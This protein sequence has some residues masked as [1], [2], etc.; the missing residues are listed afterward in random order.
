M[1]R[2]ALNILKEWYES[3][4][5]RP[6]YISGF[7]GVG[8]TWLAADFASSFF[9]ES[10]FINF[11]TDG[12]MR[13]I[14]ENAEK[15]VNLEM[16]L[17]ETFSID[18]GILPSILFVFDE[19]SVSDILAEMICDY[20]NTKN[21][22]HL[23]L[24]LTDS[25]RN[26]SIDENVNICPIHLEP[27]DFDEFL[28]AT[29]HEWYQE[30]ISA[31]FSNLRHIPGIVHN[32]LTEL[33]E[34]YLRL[35]GMP[36]VINDF[37]TDESFTNSEELQRLNIRNLKGSICERFNETMSTRMLQLIDASVSQYSL[38]NP[39]FKFSDIRKG[40]TYNYYKEALDKLTDCDI[41][42]RIDRLDEENDAAQE[43]KGAFR[44]LP[45]DTGILNC[46]LRSNGSDEESIK[47]LLAKAYISQELLKSE[48]RV[49]FWESGSGS[50]IDNVLIHGN[51]M[52]PTE[53]ILGDERRGKSISS[54]VKTFD[55][56]IILRITDQNFASA[57]IVKTVPVYAL[58]CLKKWSLP[59]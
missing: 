37:I 14:F 51:E 43:Q 13:K 36:A 4:D 32:D 34:T 19:I 12:R 25:Y 54:F 33:F 24:I 16:L 41:L 26:K 3:S 45:F 8:K 15:P 31:H 39:R 7:K 6:V 52:V 29:G 44:L 38:G 17:V 9:E 2:N 22:A 55:S 18:P 1:K 59:T 57:D 5:N 20:C 48:N 27:L 47:M 50:V 35:G 28:L 42:K 23:R 40:V 58:F 53:I 49:C 46:C 11:E 21:Y 56:D 30:I 10:I